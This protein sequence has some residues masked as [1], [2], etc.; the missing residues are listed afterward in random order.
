[1][2]YYFFFD[3]LIRIILLIFII[4]AFIKKLKEFQPIGRQEIDA[5]L[6]ILKTD[7]VLNLTL[8]DGDELYVPKRPISITVVGE[9]LN[10]TSLT[11]SE[12]LSL[13]DY[14][15]MAGG[16]TA[17]ADRERIFIIFPNG[18]SVPSKRVLFSRNASASLMPGSIIVVSRDPDPF[19]WL[20]VSTVI[21][22]VLSDLA[23]SAA[24]I[25]AINN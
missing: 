10:A 6:L 20:M 19:N 23:M 3:I 5:D 15:K 9:V 18:S 12:N 22:P 11:Y 1:M 7:P 21:T 4:S 17:G 24:A 14:I 16:M 13:E 8:Q 25:A 2:R